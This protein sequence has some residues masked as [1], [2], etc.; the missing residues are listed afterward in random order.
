MTEVELGSS[1]C[2][3]FRGPGDMTDFV[4]GG[5]GASYACRFDSV[6]VLLARFDPWRYPTPGGKPMTSVERKAAGR[7][8]RDRTTKTRNV[9]K[10]TTHWVESAT[11]K[12]SLRQWRFVRRQ[13]VVL[14][15]SPENRA[16]GDRRAR[17][18]GTSRPVSVTWQGCVD[19][20]QSAGSSALSR[21]LSNLRGHVIS[22]PR[23][24]LTIQSV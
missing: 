10:R 2:Q 1:N 16:R 13:W 24:Q 11:S 18:S 9:L 14:C 4:E 15:L 6:H 3:P 7:P 19:R 22:R 20:C 17:S 8:C 5:Y 12:R 23:S 21:L